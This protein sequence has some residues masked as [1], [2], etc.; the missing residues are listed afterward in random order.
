MKSLFL[1]FTGIKE[2]YGVKSQQFLNT[3]RILQETKK[4]AWAVEKT[5]K[6]SHIFLFHSTHDKMTQKNLILQ[7]PP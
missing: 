3:I 6:H 5:R 1:S 4:S 2:R 7:Q